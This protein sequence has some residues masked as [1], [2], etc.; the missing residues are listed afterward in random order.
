[1]S[2]EDRESSLIASSEFFGLLMNG[3][4]LFRF[5]LVMITTNYY[6]KLKPSIN[7]IYNY[8]LIPSLYYIREYL[9]AS[10]QESE[11]KVSRLHVKGIKNPEYGRIAH[12]I[13]DFLIVH[14]LKYAKL[15]HSSGVSYNLADTYDRQKLVNPIVDVCNEINETLIERNPF[16]WLNSYI[17][18][19]ENMQLDSHVYYKM[20]RIF[21]LFKSTQLRSLIEH[22]YGMTLEVYIMSAC[23]LYAT[24]CQHYY[25]EEDILFKQHKP[26]LDPAAFLSIDHLKRILEKVSISFVEIRKSLKQYRIPENPNLVFN[27]YNNALHIIHPIYTINQKYYCVVPVYIFNSLFDGIYSELELHKQENEGPRQEY[28]NNV[29]LYVDGIIDYYLR[30]NGISY[31]REIKYGNSQKTIDFIVWTDQDVLFLDCKTKHLQI[32]SKG[33]VE[34]DNGVIDSLIA[35]TKMT[36]KEIES[37]KK[38][39]SS[40]LTKDLVDL[41]IDL[42]KVLVCYDRCLNMSLSGL[43][44]PKDARLT[45]G[46]ITIENC[47]AGSPDYKEII[48]K[49]AQ[50][51]RNLKTNSINLIDENSVIFLSLRDIEEYSPIIGKIGLTR[52]L[53]NLRIGNWSKLLDYHEPNKYLIDKF[54][55]EIWNDI[56]QEVKNDA[57]GIKSKL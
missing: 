50:W 1:M 19:Q 36:N 56:F 27:Y 2:E 57:L 6:R 45:V 55:N 42:G 44:F 7:R 28:S 16:L 53:D 24:F 13:A 22:R 15:E 23:Y 8:E 47:Y 35:K 43:S 12:Y 20:Y 38:N 30:P 46:L 39:I 3:C 41:G 49:V 54:D 21:F 4:S 5:E 29:E 11:G 52:F 10:V 17:F 34:V 26:N 37:F 31:V 9:L 25:L 14:F 48:L 40:Q 33:S 51:Y 18:N 32:V